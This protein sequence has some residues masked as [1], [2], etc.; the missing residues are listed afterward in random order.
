MK[1]KKLI[2]FLPEFVKGGAANSIYSLC[3]NI[4]KKKYQIFII[5]LKNFIIIKNSKI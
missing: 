5:C 2:F 4:N 1:K 3:R